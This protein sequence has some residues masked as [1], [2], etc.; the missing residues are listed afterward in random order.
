MTRQ[1]TIG[2]PVATV[3]AHRNRM[4]RVTASLRTDPRCMTQKCTA[5]CEALT[6]TRR[7]AI[8]YLNNGQ[9]FEAGSLMG[10]AAFYAAALDAC[11]TGRSPNIDYFVDHAEKWV[12]AIRKRAGTMGPQ[13]A[14]SV[15]AEALIEID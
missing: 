9:H 11:H 3:I 4:E 7:S 13:V 5:F 8:A 6:R 12:A 14:E 10:A 2:D 15:A 1:Y